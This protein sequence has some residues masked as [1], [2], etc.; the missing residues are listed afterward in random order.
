MQNEKPLMNEN[1]HLNRGQRA[2]KHTFALS[3]ANTFDRSVFPLLL[4]QSLEGHVKTAQSSHFDGIEAWQ[5][6]PWPHYQL[7]HGF[8]NSVER[9]GILSVHQSFV[10][11]DLEVH[12]RKPST[13]VTHAL[14]PDINTSLKDL[15]AVRR[16]I[17]DVNVVVYPGHQKKKIEDT[18]FT[19][20]LIQ[21]TP[22]YTYQKGVNDLQQLPEVLEEDGFT[23]ICWDIVHARRSERHTQ[24]PS[25]FKD[26]R[27][28][29][30]FLIENGLLQEVHL[31]VGR[32]DLL[33]EHQLQ[34]MHELEDVI[35]GSQRCYRPKT[36]I[37][38]LISC[39]N[40]SGWKGL[41]VLEYL[42]SALL[43]LYGKDSKLLTPAT[44][45]YSNR[46]IRDTLDKLLG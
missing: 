29:L 21:L 15:K 22:E 17:G 39:I 19:N 40:C 20:R 30:P 3:M 13:L 14:L 31:A 27:K 37:F 41:W 23:G 25:L 12:R 7:A 42:P 44:Y 18:G 33:P 34:T 10:H 43:S 4:V 24:R 36:D 6:R 2:E 28:T 35:Q 45:I 8:V 5:A 46:K 32:I 26:W 11:W 1:D 16:H 9:E 38:D